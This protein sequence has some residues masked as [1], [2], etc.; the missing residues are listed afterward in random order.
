MGQRFGQVAVRFLSD[1][2]DSMGSYLQDTDGAPFP[3]ASPP[4][5]GRPSVPGVFVRSQEVSCSPP[6]P[7]GRPS[8]PSYSRSA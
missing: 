5:R 6:S 8:Y 3:S 4:M 7:L 2:H 1:L